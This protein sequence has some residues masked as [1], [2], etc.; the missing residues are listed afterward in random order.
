MK[1]NSAVFGLIL[2]L[3]LPLIG[4][5]VMYFLWGHHDG[6]GNFIKSLTY[7]RGMASKVCTLSLLINLIP[8]AYCNIKR[9]DY[10][11]KGIFIATMLYV[12]FI[13]LI[14]FVW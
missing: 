5:T 7:Q 6:I 3:L 10:T 1:R 4:I 2:G 12:L 11:M 14:M 13:V 8:F 9:I